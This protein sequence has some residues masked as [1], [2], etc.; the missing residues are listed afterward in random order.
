M[1]EALEQA[2]RDP[3]LGA[4]LE[5][6]SAVNAAIRGRLKAI[7]IPPDLKRDII[8]KHLERKK[9]IPFG[10]LAR[11][12][13]AAAAIVVLGI[14]FWPSLAPSP[15][16]YTFSRYRD[17]M[18]RSVQL[19]NNYM[20]M[21]STNVA[22]ILAFC[23]ANGGPADFQVP[24]RLRQLPGEGG[25]VKKWNDH[26]FFM[27]CLDAGAPGSKND[28]WLFVIDQTSMADPPAAG[29][30][31]FQQVAHLMTASWIENGKLYV[32]AAAGDAQTVQKYL[33]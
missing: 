29:K 30:T 9:I 18:A 3:E 22:T 25:S 20:Q 1:A 28:L 17:R 27:L 7:P 19:G 32:L 11:A 33:E 8:I 4:W 10:T 24:A 31:Q 16:E 14:V 23:Q 21:H 2:R 13:A 5:Q 15:N 12:L 26:P 6:H